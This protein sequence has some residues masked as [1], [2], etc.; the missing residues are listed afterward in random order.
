LISHSFTRRC[1]YF[2]LI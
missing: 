1:S 2:S